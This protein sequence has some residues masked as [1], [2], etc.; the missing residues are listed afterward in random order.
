MSLVGMEIARHDDDVK[1]ALENTL[2]PG[3]RTKIMLYF[4]RQKQV[5]QFIYFSKRGLSILGWG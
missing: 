3:S 4:N 1:N 5:F 2:N